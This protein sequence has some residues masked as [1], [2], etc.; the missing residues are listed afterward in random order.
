MLTNSGAPVAPG[1]LADP[2]RHAGQLSDVGNSPPKSQEQGRH[3]P[4]LK[5]PPPAQRR[6]GIGG[7][8]RLVARAKQ[9]RLVQSVV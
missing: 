9:E 1:R 2:R 7:Y 5:A 6:E 3:P 4:T 8:L